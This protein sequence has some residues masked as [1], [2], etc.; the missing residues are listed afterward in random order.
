MKRFDEGVYVNENLGL[1]LWECKG[2]DYWI[3]VFMDLWFVG[4]TA[5]FFLRFG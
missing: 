4:G 3:L 2:G 5:F 1:V